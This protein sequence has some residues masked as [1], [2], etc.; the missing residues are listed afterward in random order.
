MILL[1]VL[2][3]FEERLEEED[4]SRR[5]MNSGEDGE[6]KI[7]LE[8]ILSSRE[9]GRDM[10]A[11]AREDE[12]KRR[13]EVKEWRRRR[14]RINMSPANK[15]KLLLRLEVFGEFSRSFELCD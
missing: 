15:E 14:R 13:N 7:D 8:R 1:T 10:E 4:P 3:H 5:R 11:G 12:T 2:D 9:E 6:T